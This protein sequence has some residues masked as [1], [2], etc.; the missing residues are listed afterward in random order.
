MSDQG[1]THLATDALELA[2]GRRQPDAG[3]LHRS[4]R[5][6]QYASHAYRELLAHHGIAGSMSGKEDG[7]DKAVA[8]RFLGSVQRERTSTRSY[9]TRQAAR[10][11]RI[12]YI[13]RFS[14]RGRQQSYLGYVS[15]KA[16]EKIVRAA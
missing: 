1:D 16:Y 8:E 10:T 6:A 2:L 7:L 15:P 9:R 5:G 14:N 13:E 11:D 4:D 3:L 12:D